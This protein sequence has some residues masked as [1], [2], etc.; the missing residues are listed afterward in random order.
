MS[1]GLRSI[2][3]GAIGSGAGGASGAT[4]FLI[5]ISDI[6]R[7]AWRASTGLNLFAM[8]DD[9]APDDSDFITSSKNPS[10]DAYTLLLEPGVDPG[11]DFG[12]KLIY[13]FRKVGAGT[14][15]I[16]VCLKQGATTIATFTHTDISASYTLAEQVLSD[17]E[18]ATITDYTNLR[19]E[20]TAT[21][22]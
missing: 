11:V 6:S 4:L 5:P 9:E 21:K 13:R 14:A 8:V 16:T 15:D 2:G 3:G 12:H 22:A 20:A 1:G 10:A 7:G 18:A 19:F 17:A